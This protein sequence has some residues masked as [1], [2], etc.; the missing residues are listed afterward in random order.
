MYPKKLILTG[1]MGSGKS[2]LA[3]LLASKLGFSVI[4]ADKEV[5]RISGYPSIRDIISN[6]NEAHF[7]DLEAQVAAS[8]R[9]ASDVVIATGGGV[10]GRPENMSNLKFGGGVV[11]FLDTSFDEVSRRIPDRSSRPIFHDPLKAAQIYK[12]RL[13]IYRGYADLCVDTD[14]KTQDDICTEIITWLNK[15]R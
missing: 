8:L 3:P 4:D 9:N 12:E 5:I 6:V 14:P 11:I 13:P 15:Q 2:T 7:R 10:I 1:F